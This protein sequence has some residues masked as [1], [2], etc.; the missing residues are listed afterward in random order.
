MSVLVSVNH[1]SVKLPEGA[2]REYAVQ[3]VSFELRRDDILCLVGESASGKSVTASSILRLLPPGLQISSGRIDLE[4][5]D[6]VSMPIDELQR[7]RGARIGM[8]FQD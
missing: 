5:V 8:I 1:L 7:V 3:D 6:V 2:D 4:G